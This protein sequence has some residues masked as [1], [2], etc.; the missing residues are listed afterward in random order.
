MKMKKNLYLNTYIILVGISL[1]LGSCTEEI[2]DLSINTTYRG[3]VV[4]GKITTDTMKHQVILTRSGD[5]L[6]KL[7]TEYISNAD[8][9]ISDGTNIFKLTENTV[10]KGVYE[11]DPDVFGVPGKTYVLSINNVDINNDGVMETYTATSQLKNENPIDSIKILPQNIN[12]DNKGWAINLYSQDIGGGRDYYLVKILKNGK[13]ITDS[14][15]EYGVAN[16]AGF[17]GQYYD[18]LTVFFLNSN[19]IDEKLVPS[20]TITLELDGITEDYFNFVDGTI[21]EFRPKNPIFSGPSANVVT[22]LEPKGNVTGFFAAYSVKR[23]S[24]IFR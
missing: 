2:T 15:H 20:D 11:T 16:N 4:S 5:A 10:Q 21:R 7:P 14:L 3:L 23:K 19:K 12:S 1:L 9:S 6:H 18:G 13:M 24:R 17:E 8:V 22:N